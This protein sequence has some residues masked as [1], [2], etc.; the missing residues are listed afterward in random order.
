M[1]NKVVEPIDF[2]RGYCGDGTINYRAFE[3]SPLILSC[4]IDSAVEMIE[5][6]I[7]E[8]KEFFKEHNVTDYEVKATQGVY[9][10]WK[11]KL[12]VFN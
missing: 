7:K 11:R 12:I 2:L 3:N 8:M 9:D 5:Q 6:D 4:S 1:S 10:L